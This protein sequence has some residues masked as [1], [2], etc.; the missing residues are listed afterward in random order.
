MQQLFHLLIFLIQPYMFWATNSPIL[1]ST[2]WLFIQ[3]LVQCTDTA[4]DRCDSWY[5][6]D[7]PSQPWHRSAAVSVHCT[8]SCIYSKKVLLWM[9]KFVARN[10]QG[11]IKKINKWKSCCILLVVYIVVLK[12]C[13][14]TQI[15]S[16]RK[17]SNNTYFYK[18]FFTGHNVQCILF[19]CM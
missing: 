11:W 7:V 13:T 5:R 6:T 10:M 17:V 2:F 19:M 12:W 14:V 18:T 1:R 15:P 16:C 9:S 3:L 8:E 4:D